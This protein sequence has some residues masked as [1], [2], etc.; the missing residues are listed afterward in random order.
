MVI[1]FAS[2]QAK[3]VGSTPLAKR[4]NGVP[5]LA[6]FCLGGTSRTRRWCDSSRLKDL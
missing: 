2:G 5:M 1:S 3:I 6:F 4:A